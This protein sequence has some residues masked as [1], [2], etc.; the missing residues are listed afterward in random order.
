MPELNELLR[1]A[2]DSAAARARGGDFDGVVRA[3]RRRRARLAATG[4][5]GL[6]AAVAIGVAAVGLPVDP[7]PV[8]Q[9]GVAMAST[10]T[11]E[12]L[13]RSLET[14]IPYI[15]WSFD[16][17]EAKNAIMRDKTFGDAPQRFAY[18]PHAS[19]NDDEIRKL[20]PNAPVGGPFLLFA[21]YKPP[22]RAQAEQLAADLRAAPGVRHAK[23]VTV[24][25]YWFSVTVT[26]VVKAGTGQAR[27]LT[28]QGSEVRSLRGVTEQD[29]LPD[30]RERSTS[31]YVFEEPTLDVAGLEK[32]RADIAKVWGVGIEAT[33]VTPMV[34]PP[35]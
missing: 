19:V 12:Q 20:F 21:G 8:P 15:S 25:G 9:P 22:T 18:F 29:P 13:V 2:A 17:N 1:E 30:G 24:R 11:P 33:V 31:R 27:Q 32:A 26:A 16:S 10:A 5:A 4:A 23:L 3:A 6:V 28:D 35:G 14:D 7:R 34:M